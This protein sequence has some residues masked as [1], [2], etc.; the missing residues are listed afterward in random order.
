MA[1]VLIPSRYITPKWQARVPS[2]KAFV[3]ANGISASSLWELKQALLALEEDVI[4]HHFRDESHDIA[5][6]VQFVIGD[7]ELAEE[8]KQYKHRWGLI[9][10]LERHLMRTLSL[11]HYLAQR[12]LSKA[13]APFTFQSGETVYSLEELRDTLEKVSDETVAFHRE[14]VPNDIAAWVNDVIGDYEL[15]DLIQESSSRI[16]MQRF[17]SDH[18]EMLREA[19]ETC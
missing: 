15:A 14:R 19:A 4:T 1:D 10:A 13:D 8:L 7:G 18:L 11:P 16:Q 17:V 3:F 2:S 5:N 12:W 9:V 6:W